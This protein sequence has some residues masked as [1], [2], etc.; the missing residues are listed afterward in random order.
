MTRA[1]N[2]GVA[3]KRSNKNIVT[4]TSVKIIIAAVAIKNVVS[5]ISGQF[6]IFAKTIEC[7]GKFRP[8]NYFNSCKGISATGPIKNRSFTRRLLR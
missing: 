2:Q 5:A 7:I 8:L 6:V 1:T 4:G 3:S